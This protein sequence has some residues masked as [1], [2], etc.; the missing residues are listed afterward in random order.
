MANYINKTLNYLKRNG[1]KETYYAVMERL[2]PGGMADY[3]HYTYMAPSEEDL[4]LQRLAWK[5][6]K[7]PVTF[8]LLV[9]AYETKPEYLTALIDSCLA[10]TWESFELI[11]ADASKTDAVE[12]MIALYD[13]ARIRYVRL[14]ENE[15]ISGNTNAAIEEA[16][17]M[18]VGLLDHDDLLT[19]DALYEMAQVIQEKSPVLIYSDED[20]CDGTGNY[21]YE[22]HKKEKFNLDLFLTNN[23]ICHLML[24]RREVIQELKLR[25]AYDGAQDYDLALRVVDKI[26]KDDL[27]PED[28]IVHVPE[29]LY[30]WRCHSMSTAENPQSKLYAYEAGR[31]ALEDF[32]ERRGIRATVKN[33]THLGF[34]EVDY[35]EDFWYKRPDVGVMGGKILG[36]NNKITSGILSEEGDPLYVGI[37][38]HFGGYLHRAALAQDAWA[39]DVRCMKVR[40]ECKELFEQFFSCEVPQSAYSRDY[41]STESFWEQLSMVRELTDDKTEAQSEDI[42]A[43][44]NVQDETIIGER[45]YQRISLEFCRQV[46]E[47]GYRIY[48]DPKWVVRI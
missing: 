11:L 46:R 33:T 8:S 45:I 7:N 13:D 12:K 9:P 15:G 25:P 21:Y 16:T 39:V 18:Y 19:P 36:H 30:H 24:L 37:D 28:L 3:S 20:K 10:Q 43:E 35:R 1:V 34:Y 32:L 27:I 17:G 26:L 31:R 44:D 29:I 22:P 41:F 5:N 47:K 23:Y 2:T 42:Q 38:A 14:A 6:E 40:L 4:G 48:W